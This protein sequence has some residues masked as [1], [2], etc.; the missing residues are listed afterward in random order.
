MSNPIHDLYDAATAADRA[1]SDELARLYG[2]AAGDA[3]YDQ[4]G[5]ATPELLALYAEKRDAYDAYRTAA[6]PHA[7]AA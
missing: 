2:K 5:I 4:R 3:R 1:Y 7:R 6:F